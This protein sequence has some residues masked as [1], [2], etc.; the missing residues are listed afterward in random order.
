MERQDNAVVRSAYSFSLFPMSLGGKQYKLG[1]FT[2]SGLEFI[3]DENKRHAVLWPY[4]HPSLL[5]P[6]CKDEYGALFIE[7]YDSPFALKM[8][9]LKKACIYPL[10]SMHLSVQKFHWRK[11]MKQIR[12]V[13]DI[14]RLYFRSLLKFIIDLY[15]AGYCTEG[16]ELENL[17]MK[18][19]QIK[20]FG[21]AFLKS[22]DDPPEGLRG[23]LNCL[24]HIIENIYS[25]YARND[26]PTD[27]IDWL[28]FLQYPESL[29]VD[30]ISMMVG[31]VA[32]LTHDER[33]L[34]I[35]DLHELGDKHP[36]FGDLILNISLQ[37]YSKINYSDGP[38]FPC[39]QR[40]GSYKYV[41]TSSANVKIL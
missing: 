41:S 13:P 10:M 38:M 25:H 15:N 21:L 12:Y 40:D 3:Q 34:Y 28:N 22:P 20:F 6:I 2:E 18:G 5:D 39:L 11:P 1:K 27:F 26:I 29:P 36:L 23:D 32:T 35:R 24:S 19:D 16:F 33:L 7:R 9:D 8:A 4:S 30:M 14:Y 37:W 17:V 31:H